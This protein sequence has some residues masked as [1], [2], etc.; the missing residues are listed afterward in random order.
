MVESMEQL[1][2]QAADLVSTSEQILIFTGSG[3]STE[4]GIPDFRGPD[5]I[6]SK[7]DDEDF[8]SIDRFLSDSQTRK[9]LWELFAGG[10]LTIAPA[11]PNPGHYAIAE[12]E[13]MG[14]LHG[15][16]TQNMDGLH[17]K[18]GVS[19]NMVF[20]LHGDWSHA[21]CLSCNTRYP[22]EEIIEWMK[23]DIDE[24]ECGQCKGMLKPDAV[25]FGEQLPF[26]VL[27]ESKSR[28][29]SCDLCIV[30]GSTLP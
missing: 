24:P 17:Q 2:E 6:L 10:E 30:L 1:I 29:Q 20:Q 18:A 21:R 12:L 11:Q 9:L 23:E 7:Y 25:L 28:S 19:E 15:V 5:G 13:Q 3:V 16:V 8:L 22:M 27:T 26:E 4:S 14:K